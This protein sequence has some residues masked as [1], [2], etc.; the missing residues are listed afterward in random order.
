MV[1][2][3]LLWY[4][5]FERFYGESMIKEKFVDFIKGVIIGIANI[6]P[7]FS[8]GIM[9]VSFNA[10]DRIIFAASNFFSKPL[11]VIKDVWTLAL[12][13]AVGII[14]ALLG[15][16]YLLENFPIPTIM[17]FVGLIVGSIPTIFEK[18]KAKSYKASQIIVF[19]LGII[20]I[21]GI[22]LF[23]REKTM[24]VKEIDLGLIITLFFLGIIAAATMVI[25]GVSGSLILL[26]FGYYI[27]IV[28]LI[29]DFLKATV[30]MNK[31]VFLSNFFPIFALGLGIVLGVVVLSKL[32]AKL[33]KKT[34]KLVYSAILG[35][36]CASPFSIIYQLFNPKSPDTLHYREILQKN[37]VWNLIIGVVF[38]ALGVILADFMSKFEKHHPTKTKLK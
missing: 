25:P 7:G 33:I 21:V 35:M 29:K 36:I 20:F 9:A 23:A 37:I 2:L 11:K 30:S 15:I 17:L 26:A 38:L 3:G 34:P 12:G 13:G 28:N 22:P 10:Y 1:I 19:F 6:M 32:I 16:S 27:Y 24:I 31:E 8:G 5:C 4:N 14:L 18:V